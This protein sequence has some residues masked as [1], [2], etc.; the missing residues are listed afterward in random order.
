MIKII[1]KCDT[2]TFPQPQAHDYNLSILGGL[3]QQLRLL[4]IEAITAS[5]QTT[6]VLSAHI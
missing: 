6:V 4:P 3:V 2:S 1:M 5:K